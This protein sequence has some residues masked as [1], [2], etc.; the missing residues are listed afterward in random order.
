MRGHAKINQ[1]MISRIIIMFFSFLA[2]VFYA[3]DSSA[4]SKAFSYPLGHLRQFINGKCFHYL[5]KYPQFSRLCRGAFRLMN[6]LKGIFYVQ[7]PPGLAPFPIHG[8]RV[9][10]YG[11]G[12]ESV[13][14][15]PEYFIIVK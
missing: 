3:L 15:S 12:N 6:A 13:D 4:I 2:G 7:I 9:A 5:V 11:L 1:A 14:D 10:D 8:Q